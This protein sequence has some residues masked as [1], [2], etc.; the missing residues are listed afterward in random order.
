MISQPLA[1]PAFEASYAARLSSVG[2]Y[3]SP[4][5][6]EEIASHCAGWH[7]S[8]FDFRTYLKRSALRYY[9][10]YRTLLREGVQSVCDVGGMWG[11]FPLVLQDLGFAATMTEAR[12]YYSQ[13]F[14]PLFS[15]IEREGVA[16][17]DY[18]PFAADARLG[19]TFDAVTV[20][21][22]L[23]HYPHSLRVFMTNVRSLMADRGLLYLEVPNI[24]Y[25]PKRVAFLRH[26]V[27]P[28]PPIEEIWQSEVPFIGH[29]HEFTLFE[30]RA[31]ARLS[32]LTVVRE[33]YYN[34]SVDNFPLRETLRRPWLHLVP[35]L[36]PRT[37]ECLVAVCRKS[38]G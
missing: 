10:A 34:Y 32:G 15:A 37:R 27:S 33:D 30:L 18:D 20:M 19:E 26:G 8:R 25:W 4:E 6:Q 9:R 23:E 3:W 36:V 2:A 5:M 12:G 28:L 24:A 14:D 11:L 29:H 13:A 22:V 38:A 1:Y 16:V 21:A 35:A 7:P 17:V 31:V